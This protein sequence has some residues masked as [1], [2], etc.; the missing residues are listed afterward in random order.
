VKSLLL[1]LALIA[2][3]QAE[4]VPSATARGLLK[5]LIEINTTDSIGDNTAAA[6]AMARRL[7]EVGFSP[8][9]VEVVVP[10]P[11]KGNLWQDCVARAK[12][13]PFFFWRTWTWSKPGVRIGP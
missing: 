6:Q 1:S 9:D 7:R 13:G 2:S 11:Q 8:K 3:I 10:A 4:G 12:P 5:E